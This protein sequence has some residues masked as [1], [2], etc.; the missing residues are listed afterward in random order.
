MQKMSIRVVRSLGVGRFLEWGVVN[1]RGA[2]G[3]V[4][5]FWDNRVLE[6]VGMEVGQFSISC[7]FKI[8]R[9]DSCGF[10]Q[11]GPFTWSGGLNSQSMSRLDQFL[12]S[13]DWE[14]FFRGEKS[15]EL[16]MEEVEARKEAKEDFKKWV[17]MEEV[18][19]RQKS[20]EIWLRGDRNT[21][22]FHRMANA[23][24]RRIDVARLEEP[25][26]EEEVSSALLELNGDKASGPDGFTIAFLAI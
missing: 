18:S 23:H 19:W 7:R 11:G 3:G 16:S 17:L 20:R 8:V 5:V 24:K 15:R 4:V 22:Y 2:A 25:F 21:R 13:E 6:L 10:S 1:A 9:M 26:R 14:S 12:V